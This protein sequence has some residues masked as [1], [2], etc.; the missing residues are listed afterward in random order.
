MR[1]VE[2]RGRKGR[3]RVLVR[4]RRERKGRRRMGRGTVEVGTKGVAGGEAVEDLWV[5][6][7]VGMR[8]G[9]GGRQRGLVSTASTAPT[10]Y[11]L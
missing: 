9:V 3:T 8:A 7:W 6:R 5:D 4:V 2:R 10:A 11:P 1:R